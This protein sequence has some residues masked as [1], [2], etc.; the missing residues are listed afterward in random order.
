MQF[1]LLEK[2]KFIDF[3]RHFLYRTL[4]AELTK[5]G[6]NFNETQN[7]LALKIEILTIL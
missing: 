1:K 6:K 2:N 4:D 5:Y 7:I 3:R